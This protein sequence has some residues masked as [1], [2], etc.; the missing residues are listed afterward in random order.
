MMLPLPDTVQLISKE[1][2]GSA[3]TND[4]YRCTGKLGER[5]FAFYLKIAR[6]EA[7]LP[8]REAEILALLGEADVP[9]P[10]VLWCA[11]NGESIA[12]EELEGDTLTE[13]IKSVAVG[14]TRSLFLLRQY[15]RCLAQ[16]HKLSPTPGYEARGEF[17]ELEQEEV[18]L[19]FPRFR[20]VV[21]WLDKNRPPTK[22]E[23]FCHG[24]YNPD[25]V[26]LR[27]REITGVLDW[28]YA[29][30]GWCEFDVA[31]G[32]RYRGTPI[33]GACE[34][35]VFLDGYHEVAPL[36]DH[37]LTWC[38]ALV[39]LHFACW[40]RERDPQGTELHLARAEA[41]IVQGRGA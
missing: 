21:R 26:L 19:E 10:S 33:E 13:H 36:D 31:W 30:F 12:L 6:V 15:G 22:R 20:S 25:N 17:Y 34:R 39:N 35:R 14:N 29:G 38:E 16:I 37:A 40:R 8:C 28:E 23:V 5:E 2:V 24:D 32:M 1:R 9:I 7:G 3:R 27:G 41:A 4:V 18:K 11:E